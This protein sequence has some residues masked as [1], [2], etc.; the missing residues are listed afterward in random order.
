VVLVFKQSGYLHSRTP[1]LYCLTENCHLKY[2]SFYCNITLKLKNQNKSSEVD[3]EFS[4]FPEIQLP[5]FLRFYHGKFSG[6]P[7]LW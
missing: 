1:I 3:E 5:A 7:A 6:V 4:A 2:G